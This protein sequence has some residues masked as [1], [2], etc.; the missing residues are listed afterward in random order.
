MCSLDA[1]SSW[2]A[3]SLLFSLFCPRPFRAVRLTDHHEEQQ[4]FLPALQMEIEDGAFG[5]GDGDGLFDGD[6]F[7]GGVST[8]SPPSN[9]NILGPS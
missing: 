1:G 3:G 2:N 5:G 9:M 8:H 4:I 6:E 7:R